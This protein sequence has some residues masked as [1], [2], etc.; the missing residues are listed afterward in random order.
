V[1]S[2]KYPWISVATLIVPDGAAGD[3]GFQISSKCETS[4]GMAPVKDALKKIVVLKVGIVRA[5]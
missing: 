2:R 1:I 5:E 3:W 4:I